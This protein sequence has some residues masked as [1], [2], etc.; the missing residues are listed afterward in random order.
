MLKRQ[1]DKVDGAW[2]FESPLEELPHQKYLLPFITSTDLVPS[3]AKT[4][5]EKIVP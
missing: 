2:V 1:N 3:L 4:F 5:S